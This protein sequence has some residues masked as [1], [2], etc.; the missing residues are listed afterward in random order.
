MSI[1]VV[2]AVADLTINI[3][4]MGEIG[5]GQA[6][7]CKMWGY[8]QGGGGVDAYCELIINDEGMDDG[9]RRGIGIILEPLN[10]ACQQGH[11]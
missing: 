2:V 10:V 4:R 8:E 3:S 9:G 7:G 6:W 1:V 5:R 11:A